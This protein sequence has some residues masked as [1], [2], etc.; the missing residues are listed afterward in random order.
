MDCLGGVAKPTLGT[1]DSIACTGRAAAQRIMPSW[2]SGVGM[3]S[4]MIKQRLWE[5]LHLSQ[6]G[7]VKAMADHLGFKIQRLKGD[8]CL[9]LMPN[10][11][12]NDTS[13]ISSLPAHSP[14][15][16]LGCARPPRKNPNR[17]PFR[18]AKGMR[19]PLPR[20]AERD[21]FGS[22]SAI[23]PSL[24]ISGVFQRDPRPL[25]FPLARLPP[26]R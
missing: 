25:P 12:V 10:V 11:E 5:K 22:L 21:H 17:S 20:P 8:Q 2:P 14:I 24:W 6:W 16:R 7:R 19:R 4:T 9:L 23:I 26:S 1:P 13:L 3:K 15:S 18:T